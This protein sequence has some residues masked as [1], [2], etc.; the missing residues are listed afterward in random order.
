MV[1]AYLVDDPTIQQPGFALPRQQWSLLNP[2]R[3]GQ[4]T[5]VP[6]RRNGNFQTP[7]SVPAVRPKRYH[8]LSNPAHKQD[9]TVA[10][11]NYTLQ[12]MMP[13]PGW[14]AMAPK[15]I[16]QQ[17]YLSTFF[18]A[19]THCYIFHTL[20]VLISQHIYSSPQSLVKHTLKRRLDLCCSRQTYITWPELCQSP[21][22]F[23]SRG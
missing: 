8:T 5:A 20:I 11:L 23:R 14:P 21:S 15:C 3:T 2:F 17:Q 1:N 16:R 6:V 4:G 19:N 22:C 12:T 13:L 9:Y 7:I 18:Y 10:C